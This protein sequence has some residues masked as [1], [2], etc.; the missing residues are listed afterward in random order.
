LLTKRVTK[1][2]LVDDDE[3]NGIRVRSGVPGLT[4]TI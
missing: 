3:L 2:V 4:D 1:K